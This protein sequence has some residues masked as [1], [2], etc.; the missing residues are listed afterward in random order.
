M[1]E[2]IRPNTPTISPAATSREIPSSRRATDSPRPT[3]PRAPGLAWRA[4]VVEVAGDAAEHGRQHFAARGAA[5]REQRRHSARREGR[6]CGRRSRRP[7]SDSAR[8]RS[9]ATDC[10]FSRRMMRKMSF[11]SCS[12]SAAVGSSMTRMRALAG[13]RAGDLDDALLGDATGASP[14]PPGRSS[15]SRAGR[16]VLR[17]RFAHGARRRPCGS[18]VPLASADRRA[19]MFSATVMSGMTEISCGSSRTPAATAARGSAKTTVLAVDLD[20]S[21][22]SR[23]VDAGQDLH[24]RR[25]AG[26]V[27]AEQRH[28]LARRH[29]KIDIGRE[30]RRRRTTCRCRASRGADARSSSLRCLGQD[31]ARA[32]SLPIRRLADL[33]LFASGQG[34]STSAMPRLFAQRRQMLRRT[35]PA[36]N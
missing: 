11:A 34:S 17:A 12:V 15:R 35:P 32:G 10:S 33:R 9:T 27:R 26:A 28:H 4:D 22:A 21:P 14:A 16:A 31:Q 2:P 13:E 7:R 24:Q 5:R 36:G 19:M 8:C 18:P 6:R 1:P 29:D 20:S 23:G 25:L 3:G 30:L